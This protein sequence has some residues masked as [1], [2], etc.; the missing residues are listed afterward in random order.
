MSLSNSV[1][2]VKA[3]SAWSATLENTMLLFRHNSL[4]IYIIKS[5]RKMHI[6]LFLHV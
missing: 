4:T 3:I 2:T 6:N 1:Y 5:I